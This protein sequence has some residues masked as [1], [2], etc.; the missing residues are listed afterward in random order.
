MEHETLVVYYKSK[1]I[2]S[3]LLEDL[4]TNIMY[5]CLHRY[6]LTYELDQRRWCKDD[7]ACL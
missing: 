2:I 4:G 3:V 5:K 7:E 6:Y 1:Q